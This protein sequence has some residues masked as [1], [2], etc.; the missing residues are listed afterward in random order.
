MFAY[1]PDIPKKGIADA[2]ISRYLNFNNFI[3]GPSAWCPRGHCP[4]DPLAKDAVGRA[5]QFDKH[6]HNTLGA[7]QFV[8]KALELWFIFGEYL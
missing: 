3:I 7:L 1:A 8:A 2:E 4:A 5:Q 6:D